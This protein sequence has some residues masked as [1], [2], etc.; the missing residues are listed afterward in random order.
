MQMRGRTAVVGAS[1]A[2]IGFVVLVVLVSRPDGRRSWTDRGIRW[3]VDGSVVILTAPDGLPPRTR[4]TLLGRLNVG[5]QTSG[6]GGPL[7]PTA[8]GRAT[9]RFANVPGTVRVRL[10]PRLGRIDACSLERP[11]DPEDVSAV[12]FTPDPPAARE[13]A[14]TVIR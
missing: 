7:D 11:G 5:C 12:R 13:P 6:P 8:T 10:A 1:M 14:M 3:E 2:V 4:A 9:T